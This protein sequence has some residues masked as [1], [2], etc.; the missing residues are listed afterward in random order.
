VPVKVP[1]ACLLEADG[2]R[3]EGMTVDGISNRIVDLCPS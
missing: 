2:L 3:D 1:L